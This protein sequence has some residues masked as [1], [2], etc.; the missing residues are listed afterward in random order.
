M[1]SR[2]FY[3]A[4]RKGRPLTQYFADFKW[5]Y[6][7]LNSPLPITFD[8]KEMQE[9]QEQLAIMSF[10]GGLGQEYDAICFQILGGDRVIT[11]PW[12][13]KE[14]VAVVEVVMVVEVVAPAVVLLKANHPLLATLA[15]TYRG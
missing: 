7:E 1:K 12:Q 10:L 2:E 8:V 13:L 5:M 6:D 14:I 15:V 11:Q 4:D 9:Q 3:K